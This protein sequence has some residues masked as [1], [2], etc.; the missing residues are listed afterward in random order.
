M[1]KILITLLGF[2]AFAISC[3]TQTLNY[4]EGKTSIEDAYSLNHRTGNRNSL[5]FMYSIKD[6]ENTEYYVYRDSENIQL[7]GSK[8]E[9][10]SSSLEIVRYRIFDSNRKYLK[11]F[12]KKSDLETFIKEIK[13][14]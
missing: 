8:E 9:V 1:K 11:T 13:K 3:S 10:G 5:Q 14:S 4:R 12:K 7:N 2:G 6:S